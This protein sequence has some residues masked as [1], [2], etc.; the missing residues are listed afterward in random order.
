MNAPEPF[1]IGDWSVDPPTGTLSGPA[2]QRHLTPKL[3]DLLVVLAQRAGQVVTRDE[4]LS[5]VWGER[6]AVSDEP[7]TRAVAELRKILGDVRADPCYIETIPKRG[8]RVVASVR[9]A[10]QGAGARGAPARPCAAACH[11]AGHARVE[12]FD[13]CRSTPNGCA[14]R[15]AGRGSA[16]RTGTPRAAGRR[17][18]SASPPRSS[19]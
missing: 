3:T 17:S 14:C 4:L 10:S 1:V 18:R 13:G 15:S 5:R 6:G 2:G 8:Y 7:L 11:G 16:R 19:P 9:S 12:H